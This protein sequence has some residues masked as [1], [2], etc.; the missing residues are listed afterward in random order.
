MIAKLVLCIFLIRATITDIARRQIENRL[1]LGMLIGRFAITLGNYCYGQKIMFDVD[2]VSSQLIVM[3]VLV[4]FYSLEQDN[5][6][7]GDIKLL[8]VG[9]LFL[10]EKELIPWFVLMSILAILTSFI[11]KAHR[12]LPLAPFVLL[13]TLIITVM[14]YI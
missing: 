9:Q 12:R 3:I 11:I 10:A 8:L 6:A 4:M 5:F 7:A 1:V 13:S 14:D 2:T